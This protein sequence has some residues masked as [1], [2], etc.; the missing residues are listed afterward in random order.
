MTLF[1]LTLLF[2]LP[3]G[4]LFALMRMSRF[5]LVSMP[6]RLLILVM[7]GTPLILQVFTVYFSAT[8]WPVV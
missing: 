6:V 8:A 3:L 7:R 4:L 5:K 2:S 1:S